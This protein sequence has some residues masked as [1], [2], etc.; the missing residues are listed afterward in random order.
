VSASL[1]WTTGVLGGFGIYY[2]FG[3]ILFSV[4][5]WYQHTLVKPDDLSKVNRAFFTTNGIASV[6]FAILVICDLYFV[7]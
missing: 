3:A 6:A 4:L 2:L 1:I 5:L 7:L